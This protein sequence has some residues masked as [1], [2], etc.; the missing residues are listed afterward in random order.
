MSRFYSRKVLELFL[1]PPHAGVIADADGTGSAV[2]P[3]CSD[4]VTVTIRVVDGRI[5]EARFRAQGCAAAI[6]AGAAT[7]Q[8]VYNR[9]IDAA[10]EVTEE[11]VVAYLEGLPEVKLGCSVIAPEA[12]RRAIHQWRSKKT[13]S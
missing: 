10:E 12:L 6:A 1:D 8:L 9:T 5:A 11:E 13:G 2:N 4:R 3:A 7:M